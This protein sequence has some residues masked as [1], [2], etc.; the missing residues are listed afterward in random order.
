[1]LAF[2]ELQ[3]KSRDSASDLVRALMY[4]SENKLQ[5]IMKMRY[6][7]LLAQ[8]VEQAMQV[9][10]YT[11]FPCIDVPRKDEVVYSLRYGDFI[12]PMSKA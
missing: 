6:V 7:G 3:S 1:M 12:M 11:Y 9:S 10:C 5:R 8:E 4:G 2:R